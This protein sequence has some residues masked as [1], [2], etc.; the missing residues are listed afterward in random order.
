MEWKEDVKN[1]Q[2]AA[3]LIYAGRDVHHLY[4]CG[5]DASTVLHVL[6]HGSSPEQPHSTRH[7]SHTHDVLH[8]LWNSSFK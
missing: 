6:D 3:S 5:N 2:D 7:V 4:H 1:I 8:R